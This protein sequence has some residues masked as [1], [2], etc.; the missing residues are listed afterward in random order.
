MPAAQRA[1]PHAVAEEGELVRERPRA[2]AEGVAR[3]L[4]VEAH[5]AHDHDVTALSHEHVVRGKEPHGRLERLVEDG[6]RVIA[7]RERVT[8]GVVAKG[9]AR[10]HPRD[11]VVFTEVPVKEPRR[12]GSVVEEVHH[13]SA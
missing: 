9:G 4:A 11:L 7:R 8:L 10:D 5:V 1:L 3:D 2:N 13:A 6:P 12:V